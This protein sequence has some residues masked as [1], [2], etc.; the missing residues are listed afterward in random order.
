MAGTA[1]AM[2]AASRE[3]TKTLIEKLAARGGAVQAC[4]GSDFSGLLRAR[5]T[6]KQLCPG[7]VSPKGACARG[8]A[9]GPDGLLN[10]LH[11]SL[12]APAATIIREIISSANSNSHKRVWRINPQE[13]RAV[14]ILP[15]YCC[16]PVTVG[17]A[18]PRARGFR[19]SLGLGFLG[20]A[21][22]S[23]AQT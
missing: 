12:L 10:H 19:M 20:S 14:T 6:R 16:R 4:L 1:A 18:I 5:S 17:R 8:E 21:L 15:R 3:K 13:F 22:L 9:T 2:G 11:P 7:H 23:A